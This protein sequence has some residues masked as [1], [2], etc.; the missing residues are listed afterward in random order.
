MTSETF[1]D[2]DEDRSART[3]REPDGALKHCVEMVTTSGVGKRAEP[4]EFPHP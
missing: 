3:P 4:G 2:G 1:R